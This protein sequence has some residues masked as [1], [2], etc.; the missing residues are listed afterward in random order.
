MEMLKINK[1]LG[2]TAICSVLLSP[3]VNAK[4]I[5]TNMAR[6]QAMD[7][8]TG[9]VS[10]IDVPVNG[11]VIFESFS[12][13][14][15]ACKTRPPEE[16]PEN[17]AFVD[18]V[19]QLNEKSSVNVFKGW[20]LSSSPALNAVEHPIYDVWLIKCI[21]GQVDTSKLLTSDQLKDR[22]S[23]PKASDFKDAEEKKVPAELIGEAAEVISTPDVVGAI[24]NDVVET[25]P[26]VKTAVDEVVTDPNPIDEGTP[27]SL[28]NLDVV[29][30]E[31][32]PTPAT[33]DVNAPAEV[34]SEIDAELAKKESQVV[35]ASEEPKIDEVSEIIEETIGNLDTISEEPVK[36]PAEVVPEDTP[37]VSSDVPVADITLPKEEVS[38]SGQLID[39]SEEIPEEDGFELNT[40]AL[41][42]E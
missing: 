30:Q 14:V 31:T 27:K 8:I 7:K 4:E 12:I 11:E 38:S 20:M 28:I 23:L 10:V 33:E 17:F 42:E 15:R 37:T 16:A 36:T 35:P 21:D 9:R 29:E 6:M 34:I 19:D 41:S 24:T 3:I 32:K 18:V 40:E 39:F 25:I 13:N 5:D 26:E 22:D 2:F 1:L